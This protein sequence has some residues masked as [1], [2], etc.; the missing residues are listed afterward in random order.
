MSR[1]RVVFGW[2]DVAFK[3]N[4]AVVLLAG[5][6]CNYRR[7]G[8]RL[9]DSRSGHLSDSPPPSA[10][11]GTTSQRPRHSEYRTPRKPV[12]HLVRALFLHVRKSTCSPPTPFSAGVND[13]G[14][15]VTA[16]TSWLPRPF[17]AKINI[18][19][20][21]VQLAIG[22]SIASPATHALSGPVEPCPP[23]P[24]ISK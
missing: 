24:R 14:N 6:C 13:G 20:L 16:S 17:L 4:D 3:S 21:L 12:H 1:V 23:W 10:H 2:L 5:G 11:I 22:H 18:A 8:V 15:N 9:G 19:S 7:R